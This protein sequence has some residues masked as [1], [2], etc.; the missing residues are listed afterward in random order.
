MLF[1]ISALS[2]LFCFVRVAAMEEE[3]SEALLL[4]FSKEG[5][6]EEESPTSL[7]SMA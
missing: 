2:S 5:N 7:F 4:L 6:E 3:E 1:T